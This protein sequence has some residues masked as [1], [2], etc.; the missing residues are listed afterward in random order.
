[1]KSVLRKLGWNPDT[2]VQFLGVGTAL[3]ALDALRRN[4]VQA[5]VVWDTIF[6]LYEFSG[7]KFRYFRPDP[8]PQLGFTHTTNTLQETIDRD[9]ALPQGM[10][11]AMAKALV[12]MAAAEPAE[13]TKLHFKVFPASRPTGMPEE[14]AIELDSRRL[15][16]RKPVMRFEQR[17]FSRAEQLGDCDTS[18]LEGHRDLLAEGGEI[19]QALPAD[20]YF[21]RQ[22]LPQANAIDVPALIAQARAFRA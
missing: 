9:P 21:T 11:R 13:L 22:F 4:R 15:A 17:V 18:K 19:P 20:R 7:Q 3:P 12:Y 14:R 2:D 16:A 8:I 6:A 1:V 10:A 5:L